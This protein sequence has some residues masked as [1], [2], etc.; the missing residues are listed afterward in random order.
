MGCLMLA[1]LRL[2]SQGNGTSDIPTM[3]GT[4]PHFVSI[5]PVPP[6]V[7]LSWPSMLRLAIGKMASSMCEA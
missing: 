2:L 5:D 6:P 4:W 7:A 3:P 1:S